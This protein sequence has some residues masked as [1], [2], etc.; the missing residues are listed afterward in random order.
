MDELSAF[1]MEIQK[2]VDAGEILIDQRHRSKKNPAVAEQFGEI[3]CVFFDQHAFSTECEKLLAFVH[4]RAHIEYAGLYNEKTS[5]FERNRIEYHAH[6]RT[7][8]KLIDFNN[9]CNA[10]LNGCFTAEEQANAWNIP[11]W[12][13]PKVH[14]IYERTRRSEVQEL[15]AEVQRMYFEW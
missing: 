3:C 1:E 10:I 13:V 2:Y 5:V 12:Y 4:E 7:V 8:E 6:K 9:Y 11:E 14:E 15:M